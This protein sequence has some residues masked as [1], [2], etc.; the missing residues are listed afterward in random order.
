MP[1][2]S[3]YDDAALQT[4][5]RQYFDIKKNVDPD[6]EIRRR[7]K[8]VGMR[9]IRIFKARAPT[10][11]QIQAEA[12]KIDFA[13]KTRDSIKRKGGSRQKQVKAELRARIAARQFTATGWFPAVE[14]L[15][16]NPKAAKRIKGPKRGRLV[17]QKGS[18]SVSETLINEQPGAEH[19]ATKN[20]HATQRAL[21]EEAADMMEYVM[22]KQEQ[23]ARS[24]G[25]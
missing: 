7:A 9:L 3:S 11:A 21:D 23:A 5:L 19:V 14:A 18:L 16:G 15:G 24:A 8:N 13:L 17:E 25:L 12:A 20:G 4:A 10:P 6:K 22:R 2:T 1:K